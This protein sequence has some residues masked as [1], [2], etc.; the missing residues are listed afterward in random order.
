MRTRVGRLLRTRLYVTERIRV[1]VGHLEVEGPVQ[2]EKRMQRLLGA[3]AVEGLAGSL[4][5]KVRKDLLAYVRVLKRVV[6]RSVRRSPWGWA[7][8]RQGMHIRL[9]AESA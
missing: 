8:W 7:R 4:L 3:E 5:R 2:A 1:V 6:V 9:R